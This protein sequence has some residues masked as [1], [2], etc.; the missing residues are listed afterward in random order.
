MQPPPSFQEEFGDGFHEALAALQT[1][2]WT[3]EYFQ[4]GPDGAFAGE[5]LA[6][7]QHILAHAS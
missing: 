6:N 2:L 1:V 7:L 4:K 5:I 3:G